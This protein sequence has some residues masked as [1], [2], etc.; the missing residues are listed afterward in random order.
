M[1]ES[2]DPES[3][4]VF[5][6][7]DYP[8]SSHIY[9]EKLDRYNSDDSCDKL[10]DVVYCQPHAKRD[11]LEIYADSL[12]QSENSNTPSPIWHDDDFETLKP[13]FSPPINESNS[14]AFE[15]EPLN[16]EEVESF[17]KWSEI[18]PTAYESDENVY[19][20]ITEFSRDL[21]DV[22][23]LHQ[24]DQ[25]KFDEAHFPPPK[26]NAPTKFSSTDGLNKLKNLVQ[27]GIMD[28]SKKRKQ[29]KKWQMFK[30]SDH[31][32][33]PTHSAD[34]H[35]NS[36]SKTCAKSN[37]SRPSS[38][39]TPSNSAAATIGSYEQPCDNKYQLINYQGS[40]DSD[41][42]WGSDEFYSSSFTDESE[43]ED[44]ATKP[45]PP[46]PKKLS[47]DLAQAP[48][49][50]GK[51]RNLT[52][53]EQS[54]SDEES[55]CFPVT[56][57]PDKFR[58]PHLPPAPT[59]LTCNQ[60]KRR[61]V[62]ECIIL[63][64]KSYIESLQRIIQDYEC[65]I[66]EMIGVQKLKIR[67][68]LKKLREI[69]NYHHMFQIEL[70]ERVNCW[71]E[72]EKIGD[73]FMASFSKSMVFDAYSIY[74][75]NFSAA[76]EEIKNLKRTRQSF[77]DFL[78]QKETNSPD[79]L[80]IFGLMVKPIQRFPQFIMCLQ[81]ML[82]YTPKE[83]V[84]R[85]ALQL[86][87]T[88]LEN[89]AHKLNEHKRENEQKF[90]AKQIMSKIREGL[91][92]HHLTT[93]NKFLIRQDDMFH[94]VNQSQPMKSKK[95]RI[96]MLNDTLI[97]VN[98]MYRDRDGEVTERY[99]HK[100]TVPLRDVDL[101]VN[102][103]ISN[104]HNSLSLWTG[105]SV[106]T[107]RTDS[108][109]NDSQ[110]AYEALC[111]MKHDYQV[112]EEISKLV[113]SL[114]CPY[115]ILT[116]ELLSEMQRDLQ[117]KI[118]DKHE[119]INLVDGCSIELLL[120]D[121][122]GKVS[123][124][125][126]ASSPSAKQNW[127]LDFQIAKLALSPQNQQGWNIPDRQT[128][129]LPAYFV[130]SLPIDVSSDSSQ[131]QCAVGVYLPSGNVGVPH[132]WVCNTV[133]TIGGQVSI[134]SVQTSQNILTLTESF[135]A[136]SREITCVEKIPGTGMGTT[137]SSVDT[138][139]MATVDKQIYIYKLCNPKGSQREALKVFPLPAMALCLRYTREKLFAA[140]DSGSVLIFERQQDE[141]GIWDTNNPQ[142]VNLD[143][144]PVTCLLESSSDSC[145][146][147]TASNTIYV[148]NQNTSS[149]QSSHKLSGSGEVEH[150]V[151]TGVGLWVSYKDS[152]I[153]HLYH[154]ETLDLL[155]EINIS[156]A[157]TR[158]SQTD[159]VKECTVSCLLAS[160]GM[161]WIGTNV[162]LLLSFPLPRLRDGVPIVSGRPYVA[163]HGH[164]GAI[165]F[166]LPF[167]SAFQTK[168]QSHLTSMQ[169]ESFDDQ[170]DVFLKVESTLTHSPSTERGSESPE[171]KCPSV[172]KT[173]EVSSSDEPFSDQFQKELKEKLTQRY[174]SAPN[175][176][177]IEDDDDMQSLYGSLMRSTEHSLSRTQ[178]L[179]KRP[180][181]ENNA[182]G[183]RSSTLFI[184]G[185]QNGNNNNT[186]N[187]DLKVESKSR[188][189]NAEILS[190]KSSV[191]SKTRPSF[192]YHMMTSMSFNN[193]EENNSNSIIIV[194]GGNGYQ[195]WNEKQNSELNSRDND[196]NLLFWIYKH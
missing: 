175:L 103:S 114:K 46:P 160:R 184:S 176:L 189:S 136:T 158:V 106:S 170:Q 169:Q 153:I 122:S 126:Q 31:T 26:L 18:V 6:P 8:S 54:D 138:V 34:E 48:R 1:A 24:D 149:L 128:E 30:K 2:A 97:C 93:H 71:D 42:S 7:S 21:M 99:K 80:S 62:V 50:I 177:D 150:I 179:Y 87:V 178:S 165:K 36:W 29:Q 192:S 35:R 51:I 173:S 45:L 117:C 191:K 188:K 115:E 19:S 66:L 166:L 108:F 154:I 98:V 161:L 148:I 72:N 95:R 139:W 67:N 186:C 33:H 116:E 38:S 69:L 182:L 147:A 16:Q 74:V 123:V 70:A 135:P 134:I 90:A 167:T 146:L 141:E 181:R 113:G 163:Y 196:A 183:T 129:N 4:P 107:M 75:N 127:C 39:Q 64:E 63:S 41:A 23:C 112:L 152:S 155:Q 157:G 15:K 143:T 13:N 10:Y 28:S 88:V 105:D 53:K 37:Q 96:F 68:S 185:S 77:R 164:K 20:T 3:S 121:K 180:L 40:H 56:L 94:I 142:I 120:P 47:T 130:S 86:A 193:H 82:K 110:E 118:Q 190:N 140:L 168:S 124:L 119:Q 58:P 92:K 78:K 104:V 12:C 11:S 195:C 81:D 17:G 101:K 162:G 5:K 131:V 61:C 100:W 49:L 91:T 14:E 84:D 156:S 83:H 172:N 102:S 89:L 27:K 55:P 174:R 159:S 60:L 52:L 145:I 171:N 133:P 194:S 111:N 22:D 151:P 137:F 65:P 132:V 125:L 109:E 73:I 32:V 59:D 85:R 79:R 44:Y 144:K 57:R 187:S 9:L 76:M 43:E 25:Y